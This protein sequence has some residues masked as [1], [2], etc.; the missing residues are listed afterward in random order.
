MFNNKEIKD[1][2]LFGFLYNKIKGLTSKI[3][4]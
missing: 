1:L 4:K 3:N 2:A